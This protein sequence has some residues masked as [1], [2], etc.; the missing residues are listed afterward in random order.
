MAEA[1]ASGRAWGGISGVYAG[2]QT[3]AK[4]IRSR[5]DRANNL[6]GACGAGAAFSAGSGVR[7]AVQG[8][9]SFALFSYLIDV[10]T[11]PRE[12]VPQA[13]NRSDEDILKGKRR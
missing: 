10:F 5:D 11:T 13:D 12:T 6:V 4:V 9:A 3:A 8:C 1:K 7:A 2:L